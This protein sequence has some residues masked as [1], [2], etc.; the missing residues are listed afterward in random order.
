VAA[1]ADRRE[2]TTAIVPC[3]YACLSLAQAFLVLR[4]ASSLDAYQAARRETP[5]PPHEEDALLSS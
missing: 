4:A 5:A 2:A 3:V 1:A